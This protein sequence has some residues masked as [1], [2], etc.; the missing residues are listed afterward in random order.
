MKRI[1]K[2]SAGLGAVLLCA[3]IVPASVHA[4]SVALS[5]P[6]RYAQVD[7]DDRFYYQLN[8]LYPE[9]VQRRDL[10]VTYRVEEGQATIVSGQYLRA[11]ETQASF[12]DYIVIPTDAREGLHTIEIAVTDGDK[13]LAQVSGSFQVNPQEDWVMIYFSILLAAVLLVGVG[14]FV[15]ILIVSRRA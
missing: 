9:N 11:V 2:L 4:A 14:L 8:V 6:D 5:I 13:P 15:E 12:S 10:T 3:G 1:L 7:P